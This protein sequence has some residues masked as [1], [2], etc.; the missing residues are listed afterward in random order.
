MIEKVAQLSHD[1]PEIKTW[2]LTTE[3]ILNAAF[4]MPNGEKHHNTYEFVHA[5]GGPMRVG[6]SSARMAY[7]PPK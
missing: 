1:N 7:T 2:E 6:M 4:G 5:S 3:N